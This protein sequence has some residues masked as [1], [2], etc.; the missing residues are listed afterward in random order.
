M[1]PRSLLT[2]RFLLEMCSEI[3]SGTVVFK[4]SMDCV[5]NPSMVRRSS[6]TTLTSGRSWSEKSVEIVDLNFLLMRMTRRR[7]SARSWW[8]LSVDVSSLI[9]RNCLRRFAC[10]LALT[11]RCFRRRLLSVLEM[12]S[13]IVTFINCPN[14]TRSLVTT[15]GDL[16]VFPSEG[17]VPILAEGISG[18]TV[19]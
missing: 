6:W 2:L 14:S 4:M 13:L 5:T 16:T 10:F 3:S 15:R 19:I 11:W 17:T 18:E 9:R 1:Y 12:T 8:S 7:E